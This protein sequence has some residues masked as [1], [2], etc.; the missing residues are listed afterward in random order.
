M[1]TGQELGMILL[2]FVAFPQ[3]ITAPLYNS[4]RVGSM[5]PP[6]TYGVTAAF[7]F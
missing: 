3:I 6:R 4:L 1:H 7:N 2:L 5:L